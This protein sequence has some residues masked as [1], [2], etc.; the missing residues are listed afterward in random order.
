M[1][2]TGFVT[3]VVR[4]R[5][6][7]VISRERH[8]SRSFVRAYNHLQCAQM[9]GIAAPSPAITTKDT[10]GTDRN[11]RNGDKGSCN[12]AI[13]VS[14]YG[15]RV[16]TDNTAVD[17]EQYALIAACAEG[18]GAGEMEHQGTSFNFV[19]VAGNVCSFEVERSI[20]NNSGG[21]IAVEEVAIYTTGNDTADA[22]RYFMVAR[23][24]ISQSVPDGGAITMTYTI[25]VVA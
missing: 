7:K 20:V 19:G 12:A 18:T 13:G 6:G 2:I 17:I 5:N 14:A 3:A 9:R 11:L 15:I 24:L 1:K 4:D 8:Q 23:D 10:G 16:G 25:R 22:T 21:A